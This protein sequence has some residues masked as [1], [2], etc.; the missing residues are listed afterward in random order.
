MKKLI[1]FLML[2][3]S[4]LLFSQEYHFKL[5]Y[6][7][8]EDTITLLM[9]NQDSFPYSIEFFGQPKVENMRSVGEHFKNRYVI[10]EHTSKI[11]LAQFVPLD[12]NKPFAFKKMPQLKLSPGNIWKDIDENYI[13]DLPYAKGKMFAIMQGYNGAYSHKNQNALD[14]DMPEGTKVLAA[15]EGVV[16]LIKQNS[17]TGCESEICAKDANFINILHSDGTM[18]SY[19]HLKFNSLKVKRGDKVEKGQVIALSGNTGWSSGPH[20]H[21]VCTSPLRKGK[22]TT[23]KTLFRTGRKDDKGKYLLQGNKYTNY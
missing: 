4:S 15:R 10:E 6:Q 3:K 11:R 22:I 23:L 12:I 20:L 7:K 18:A 9:D 1:Y 16:M 14:F 21:F 17:N 19:V 13:Y 8:K 5:Y 2:I